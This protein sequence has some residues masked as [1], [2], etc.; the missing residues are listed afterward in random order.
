L[1]QDIIEV[2]IKHCIYL[3]QFREELTTEEIYFMTY[4]QDVEEAYEKWVKARRAEGMIQS[5]GTIAR[6][7]FGSEAINSEVSDRLSGLTEPQLDEFITKI[8]EW[9]QPE[10]MMAWLQKTL[11]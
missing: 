6:A 3:E 8:L 11:Q 1:R 10:E 2:S 5:V 7:K 4:V 9:Q